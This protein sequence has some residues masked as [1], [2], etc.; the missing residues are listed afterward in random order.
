MMESGQNMHKSK[1]EVFLRKEILMGPGNKTSPIHGDHSLFH[2]GS[3]TVP[4]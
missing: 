3:I 2:I 1:A 4:S